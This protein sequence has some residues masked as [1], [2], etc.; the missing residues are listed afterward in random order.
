MQSFDHKVDLVR[1][2]NMHSKHSNY[3]ALPGKLTAL[4]GEDSLH[5]VSRSEHA[6]LQFILKHL[7]VHNKEVIDIG[8]NTGFFS[9]ELL[10][11]GASKV[12]AYEGNKNH[13]DFLMHASIATGTDRQLYVV[14]HY[15]DFDNF[16]GMPPDVIL[17]LNVMHHIG[18]DYGDGTLSINNAK[19]IILEHLNKLSAITHNLVFQMGFNWKGDKKLP[20]FDNGTKEEMIDYISKGIAYFW[21]IEHIGIA[22]RVENEIVYCEK[23]EKNIERDDSLGEFLNRPLFLLMSNK[24]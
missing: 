15:F 10:D 18:D 21:T 5:T 12:I 6:R 7:D 8:A 22:N 17:L 23:N 24:K 14:D 2:Y 11:A 16:T 9:F 1:L 3:Q 19:K 20:L 13:A 4:L